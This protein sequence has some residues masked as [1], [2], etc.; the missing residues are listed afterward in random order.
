MKRL[1]AT[2]SL[3]IS[4]TSL[5]AQHYPRQIAV[6]GDSL[7]DSG[8]SRAVSG[9][10]SSYIYP[11]F[12][13]ISDGV[14]WPV[15]LASQLDTKQKLLPYAQGGTNYAYV[16]AATVD[17]SWIGEV[18][19]SITEQ[20]QFIPPD[21][22]RKTPF[23]IFGGANDIF[24]YNS[25]SYPTP[26]AIAA[27][28]LGKI[29]QSVHDEGF[30]YLFVL[31]M[32]NMG[33]IPSEIGASDGPIFTVQA[34]I[35]NFGL[36]QQLS[37][38][39]F[40]VVAVDVASFF[41]GLLSE[42]QQY[43][44]ATVTTGPELI[45]YP[46]PGGQNTAGFAF[47]YDATHFAE[48][49]NYR[50]SDY[51]FS[52]IS[53]VECYATLAETPITVVREQTSTIRQQLSPDQPKRDP[54]KFYF[55][56][57]GT[58][59]PYAVPA[60]SDSCSGNK[61]HGGTFS[62][63]TIAQ[64]SDSW[65]FGV[66]GGASWNNSHCHTQTTSC[67]YQL[68]AYNLSL[69][70]N[71]TAPRIF[72]KGK[73]SAHQGGYVNTVFNLA[74]LD[75]KDIKRKF[76]IGPFF[77]QGKSN[78]QGMAYSGLVYGAY[79][80]PSANP[81]L[82]TGP[83]V[84]VEYQVIFVDGYTEF[85]LNYGNLVFKNQHYNELSTGIGWEICFEHEAFLG[86]IFLSVNRQWLGSNRNIYFREKSLPAT[87]GIWPSILPAYNFLSGGLNFSIF[88]KGKLFLSTGYSFNTGIP[89]SRMR[90]QFL[91]VAISF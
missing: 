68:N 30:E 4:C 31:N 75:F 1:V 10:F 70:S 51:I 54:G 19:P 34:G 9:F 69:F 90:E 61:F 46:L 37:L 62:I 71:W 20:V 24:A 16:A 77:N 18:N 49:L 81:L 74:W 12:C 7:S 8:N 29:I 60:L 35:L 87:Y 6:L 59:V 26:G 41:N 32:P 58:Y 47:W 63:G 11:R 65:N 21:L 48:A 50:L 44:F 67:A 55:F 57:S 3:F 13:P 56:G 36:Q 73:K 25:L 38:L 28:N 88:C 64:I 22:S 53:G 79:H 2:L 85:G 66:G 89:K 72:E 82:S 33:A 40:P 43:G 84:N 80:L 76:S 42:Y 52:M 86:E 23:F 17:V 78:T 83:L 15:L 45:P 39:D 5:T 91:D 27:V 14:T